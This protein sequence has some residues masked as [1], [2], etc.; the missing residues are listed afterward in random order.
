MAQVPSS[1]PGSNPP[2]PSPVSGSNPSD[3]FPSSDSNPSPR[4]QRGSR[5]RGIE[6]DSMDSHGCWR[7]RSGT[8]PSPFQRSHCDQDLDYWSA[9]RTCNWRMHLSLRVGSI[10]NRSGTGH[11]MQMGLAEALA[12]GSFAPRTILEAR[13]RKLGSNLALGARLP[14]SLPSRTVLIADHQPIGDSRI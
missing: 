2:I 9:S 6:R 7:A 5:R 13:S 14:L 10:P 8:H 3:S 1:S 11:P 4:N 12:L